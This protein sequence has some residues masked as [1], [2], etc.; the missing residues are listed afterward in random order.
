M[1]HKFIIEKNNNVFEITDVIV[2]RE[3]AMY[4]ED[5]ENYFPEKV[6]SVILKSE[7]DGT[8]EQLQLDIQNQIA[9]VHK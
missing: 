6:L 9:E 1:P 8:I 7:H 2:P 5:L 3:G 4:E